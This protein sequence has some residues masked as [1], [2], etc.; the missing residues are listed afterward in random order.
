MTETREQMEA[1][2]A[3]E[4]A[5]LEARGREMDRELLADAVRAFRYASGCKVITFDEVY[6]GLIAAAPLMPVQQSACTADAWPGEVELREIRIAAVDEALNRDRGSRHNVADD[7]VQT[8][9][10][11]LHAH[12]TAGSKPAE[13]EW[14]DWHGGECPVPAGTRVEVKF[15]TGNEAEC[16]A[17]G[18]DSTAWLHIHGPVDVIAYRILGADQ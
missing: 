16:F 4:L 1:R 3:A 5:A 9:F 8:A 7:A 13:P 11:R 12:V 17:T 14:I 2:H 6:D 10:R 18:D 15:R